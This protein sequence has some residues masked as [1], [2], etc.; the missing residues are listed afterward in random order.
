MPRGAQVVTRILRTC[1]RCVKWGEW[2]CGRAEWVHVLPNKGPVGHS[3]FGGAMSATSKHP[4][5]RPLPH[6]KGAGGEISEIR[7]AIEG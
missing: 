2:D 3:G 1:E 5:P 6:T 7:V 4:E